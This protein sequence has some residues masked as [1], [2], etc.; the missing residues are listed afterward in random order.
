MSYSCGVSDSIKSLTHRGF[1]TNSTDQR[2]TSSKKTESSLRRPRSRE[3]AN[4]S[5]KPVVTE[6]LKDL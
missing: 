5:Y 4:N 2:K 3:T 1:R 6:V